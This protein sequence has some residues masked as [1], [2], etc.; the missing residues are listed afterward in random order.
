MGR[1]VRFIKEW[2]RL[3]LLGKSMGEKIAKAVGLLAGLGLSVLFEQQL[4]L[5]INIRPQV[6]SPALP[7]GAVILGLLSLIYLLVT[8]GMAWVRSIGPHLIISDELEFDPHYNTWRLRVT[9]KN[10]KPVAVIVEIDKIWSDR[11]GKPINPAIF[12]LQLEWSD[13]KE[14]F[15]QELPYDR[16]KTVTVVAL[17]L[18]Q[19]S[20]RLYFRVWGAIYR[21]FCVFLDDVQKVYCELSIYCPDYPQSIKR[22][23][24]FERDVNDRLNFKATSIREADWK[25]MTSDQVLPI[26]EKELIPVENTKAMIA[27][28]AESNSTQ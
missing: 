22:R 18:E 2:I 11:E 4:T 5:T 13:T 8:G 3:A 28:V 23:F 24:V 27:N 19:T 7:L 25:R 17:Q 1:I 26:P 9:N 21:H 20:L 14:M 10:P 12:P 6:S 16:P 15:K